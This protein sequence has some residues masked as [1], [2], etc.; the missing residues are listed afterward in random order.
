MRFLCTMAIL[1][2]AA[3]ACAENDHV[4]SIT[5]RPGTAVSFY[6]MKRESAKATLVLLA[7]GDGGIDIEDGVPTSKNFLVRSRD[8]F[9]A[10]GFNLAIIDKEDGLFRGSSEHIEDVRRVAAY[11]RKDA[12]VPVWLVGTSRG[13]ISATAVATVAGGDE[14]GG[15]VLTSSITSRE[16]GAV[17]FQKLDAVRVPVLVV[18]HEWDACKI[19][20]PREAEGIIRRLKNAPIKKIVY[21]K[22]GATPPSGNPCK[23]L[24][25]HGF[26][27]VEKETAD[28]ISAWIKNPAP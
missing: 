11:L 18:H 26:I 5:T 17:P 9:A 4:E 15:I 20:D 13:T 16:P 19:C 21:V 8:Y 28:L 12:K 27:G 7:G 1:L 2:F 22:A 14:L 25:Y 6:Y 23:A 3:A 10:N 24:H